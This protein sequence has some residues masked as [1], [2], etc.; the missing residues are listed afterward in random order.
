MMTFPPH[1]AG[2][3]LEHN[4]YKDYYDTIEY[5]VANE[6]EFGSWIPGEREKALETG[7]V[8]T[9]HWYPETPVGFHRL[10]AASLEKLLEAANAV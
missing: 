9:L 5:G 2:L 1:K 10:A 4:G 7:E 3:T 6:D 8:W